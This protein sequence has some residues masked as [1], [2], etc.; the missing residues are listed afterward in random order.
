MVSGRCSLQQRRRCTHT[1]YSIDESWKACILLTC[2][3]MLL[4]VWGI[5]ASGCRYE[6]PCIHKVAEAA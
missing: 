3:H 6:P 1:N 2:T 4:L 5:S